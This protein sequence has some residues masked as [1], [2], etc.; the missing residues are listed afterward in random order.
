VRARFPGLLATAAA[1]AA[2]A[3]PA[4]Q[5][6]PEPVAAELIAL[7]DD[8]Q[9][10]RQ[11][12]SAEAMQDPHFLQEMIRGDSARS[13]RLRAI[14]AEHGWP[15]AARAGDAA[16]NAAF[17]ILQHSPF[18]DFQQEMLP[19]LE[20]LARDGEL[21]AASVAMLT[22]RVLVQQGRPQRYG[23]QFEF[24][25]GELRMNPVED[26]AGLEERRRAMG[27]PPMSEY[28]RMLREFYDAPVAAPG[29]G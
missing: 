21:P 22:D 5:P 3:P 24:V 28:L 16:A 11:G 6:F 4:P 1:L 14:V 20:T 19:T 12:M 8:D 13:L 29:G 23:T 26:E 2:C 17:L 7:G 25:E 27:L 10:V 15:D 18:D 9:R